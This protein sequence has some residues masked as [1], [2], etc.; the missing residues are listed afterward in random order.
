M[1]RENQLTWRDGLHKFTDHHSVLNRET[2]LTRIKVIE[3]ETSKAVVPSPGV[4][5]TNAELYL[6]VMTQLPR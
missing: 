3:E 4:N 6:V 2:T 5:V 1:K